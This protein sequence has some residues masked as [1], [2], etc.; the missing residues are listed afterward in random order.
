MLVTKFGSPS[1][2]C[3][4]L[5]ENDTVGTGGSDHQVEI[6]IGVSIL[7]KVISTVGPPACFHERFVGKT[8]YTLFLTGQ[9]GGRFHGQMDKEIEIQF[10]YLSTEE[11]HEII[12]AVGEKIE[13]FRKAEGGAE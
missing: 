2:E 7:E 6:P 1:T 5:R 10:G 13:K 9:I 11:K 3:G 8:A 12:E 4:Q